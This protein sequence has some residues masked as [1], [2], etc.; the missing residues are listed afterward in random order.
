MADP[1]IHLIFAEKWW[2]TVL[3]LQILSVGLGI[4]VVGSLAGPMILAQGRYRTQLLI[5]LVTAPLFLLSVI[6]VAQFG[7]GAAAVALV[8]TFFAITGGTGENLYRRLAQHHVE[9][10]SLRS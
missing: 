2:P 7:G 8:V 1:L 10:K 3:P 6:I 4:R 5:S 9:K